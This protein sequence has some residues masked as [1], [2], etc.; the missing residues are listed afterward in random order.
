M[1]DERD[2]VVFLASVTSKTVG[3]AALGA[4]RFDQWGEFVGATAG[5]ARDKSFLR[6]AFGN[7]AACGIPRANNQYDLLVIHDSPHW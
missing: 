7:C 1:L 5:Y 6:E 2:H 4:Y 3:F